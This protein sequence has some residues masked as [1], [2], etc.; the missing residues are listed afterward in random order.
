M[1]KVLMESRS[2]TFKSNLGEGMFGKVMSAY[3]TRLKRS[4]AIK[5]IDKKKVNTSYLE[6]FLS[7]E[8]EIIRH[9]NHPNIIKTLD[10]FELH[11]NKVYVVMELCR[12]GDVLKHIN[13]KGPLPEQAARR[14]FTQLCEAV[15][16]LHNSDVV[17]RDLKCENLLLDKHYNLKVCDFGFSKRLTHA[18]GH[19]VLSETFCGTSTYAAPE[20]SRNVPYDPKVSDV[21]SM[22]VVLYM[23]LHASMPYDATNVRKMVRIQIQHIVNFPDAPSVSPEA[24]DLIRTMLNPVVEQRAT[25]S[26]ILQSSWMLLQGRVEDSTE[27]PTQKAGSQQ[28]GPS[29]DKDKEDEKLPKVNSEPGGGPSSSAPRH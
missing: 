3:S 22:A 27:A 23:M 17:H 5:V 6:K 2:Y 9:L 16:Y 10:I 24:K 15:Q 21:W 13:A 18:H 14:L 19:V 1:N 4:V 26:N 8:M 28:G 7:R 12:N 11:R 29:E 25:I 20:I